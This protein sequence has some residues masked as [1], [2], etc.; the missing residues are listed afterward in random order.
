MQ[1]PLY[2]IKMQMLTTNT[3]TKRT[4]WK[5]QDHIKVIGHSTWDQAKMPWVDGAM[6]SQYIYQ[7]T[8][9]TIIRVLVAKMTTSGQYSTLIV[10]FLCR[11]TG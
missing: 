4:H 5:Y 10:L 9:E 11:E 8:A 6:E 2:G 3:G 7:I 1:I